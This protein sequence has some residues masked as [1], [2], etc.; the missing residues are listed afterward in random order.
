[1]GNLCGSPSKE[2][3]DDHNGIDRK[4]MRQEKLIKVS[5][6]KSDSF[7]F[8]ARTC[9]RPKWRLSIDNKSRKNT[10]LSILKMK[11]PRLM[12]RPR[13][14]RSSNIN[15]NKNA[16]SLKEPKLRLLRRQLLKR[17]NGSGCALKQRRKSARNVKRQKRL[18]A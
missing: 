5:Q 13:S 10:I 7:T 4:N 16:L 3:Y 15:K 6:T 2:N 11:L 18:N 12:R 17:L 1:M 9:L 14:L 8:R